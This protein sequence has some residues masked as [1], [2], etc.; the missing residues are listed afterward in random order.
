[1]PDHPSTIASRSW[2]AD[3]FQKRG[4][5]DCAQPLMEEIVEAQERVQGPDHPDLGSA[6]NNLAVLLES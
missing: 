1:G 3:L 6:L 5:A 4:M 2:L